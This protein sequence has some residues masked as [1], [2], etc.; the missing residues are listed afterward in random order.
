MK[1][2]GM[3]SSCG[4]CGGCGNSKQ[5]SQES[6]ANGMQIDT[7][8]KRT[9]KKL[10][11]ISEAA[12]SPLIP[13]MLREEPEVPDRKSKSDEILASSS[14]VGDNNSAQME[15]EEKNL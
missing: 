15:E 3:Q 10:L 4:G 9:P 8:S 11:S 12:P 1:I 6:G 7:S 13:E 2:T 5:V 14:S